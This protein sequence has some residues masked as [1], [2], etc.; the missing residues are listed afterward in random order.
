MWSRESIIFLS[1]VK[2]LDDFLIPDLGSGWW[3]RALSVS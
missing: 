1:S 2:E 3:P